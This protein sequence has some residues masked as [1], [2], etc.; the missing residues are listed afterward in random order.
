MRV[1]LTQAAGALQQALVGIVA[2]VLLAG[3]V[4]TV[5]VPAE[6]VYYGAEIDVAP[7]PPQVVEVPP[8]R[9]GFVWAPG[10][11][12]WNGHQHVWVGGRWIGERAGYHWA[13]DRWEQHNGRW[14]LAKGHWER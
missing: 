10:Y 8:P 3:C 1:S 14:R 5:R 13:P 12:N 9:V 6:P 11:W 7:P 2:A 4:A